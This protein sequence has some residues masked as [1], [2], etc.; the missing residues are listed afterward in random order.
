MN[1]DRWN[2]LL[3]HCTVFIVIVL[4]TIDAIDKDIEMTVFEDSNDEITMIVMQ[5]VMTMTMMK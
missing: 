3:D 1:T 4:I 2:Q 5:T